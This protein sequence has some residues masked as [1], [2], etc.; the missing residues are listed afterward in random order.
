MHELALG[1]NPDVRA[2]SFHN[3][4]NA[5]RQ[6]HR[7]AAL[8]TA[9]QRIPQNAR[10]HGI[11]A[12]MLAGEVGHTWAD[13][14][15]KPRGY[16]GGDRP[17]NTGSY[18]GKT[19]GNANGSYGTSGGSYG[20]LGGATILALS[21][22]VTVANSILTGNIGEPIVGFDADPQVVFVAGDDDQAIYEWSGADVDKFINLQ[23]EQTVL[24]KS[25]RL[26]LPIW[27]LGNKIAN[28]IQKR[29][30]KTWAASDRPA[31]RIYN[32]TIVRIINVSKY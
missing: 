11:D 14:A 15:W 18:Y 32:V 2:E 13:A 19:L 3:L 24:R 23:G 7:G 30:P 20:G 25:Y 31:C 8:H 16:L 26:P 1:N 22:D 9:L 29:V 6:E 5:R 28:T 10:S 17:G 27:E 12:F 4:Q 21:G